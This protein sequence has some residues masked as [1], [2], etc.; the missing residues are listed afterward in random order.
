MKG[1]QMILKIKDRHNHW[2]WIADIDHL[3][4]LGRMDPGDIDKEEYDNPPTEWVG[5]G[6]TNPPH[7]MYGVVK[8][9]PKLLAVNCS[10]AFLINAETGSTIDVVVNDSQS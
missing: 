3:E 8:G 1:K 4:V 10:Q 5:E 9:K 7:V 6:D 2:G